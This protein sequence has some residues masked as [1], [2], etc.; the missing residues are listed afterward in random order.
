MQILFTFP[1]IQN[2]DNFSNN[3]ELLEFAIIF[4]CSYNLIVWFRGDI[5]RKN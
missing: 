5:L 3:P 2:K 1:M 4:L